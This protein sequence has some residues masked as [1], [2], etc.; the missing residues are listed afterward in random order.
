MKVLVFN[1]GSSSLKYRL[2]EMPAER[3][4]AGGEAQR[5]GPRTA[6][7]GR[8]V[9]N[10]GG[11]KEIHAAEMS[12]HAVALRE[13]MNLLSKNEELMPDVLGHRMVHGGSRFVRPHHRGRGGARGV[14]C[15]R[16][17]GSSA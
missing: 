11:K 13:V 2:I 16:Q 10:V 8:V 14:E 7:P 12:D 17:S 15:H 5:V 3:E 1:C 6:E 4:L 9:H